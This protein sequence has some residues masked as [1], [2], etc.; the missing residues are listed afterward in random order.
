MKDDPVVQV[1]RECGNR[2]CQHD[3]TSHYWDA[4][5]SGNCLAKGCN[6]EG[7]VEGKRDTMPCPPP[8]EHY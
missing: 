3:R 2:H 8:K 6:C 5:G 4:R 1:I 7:F